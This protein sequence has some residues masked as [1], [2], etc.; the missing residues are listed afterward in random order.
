MTLFCS[1][2][3]AA[4]IILTVQDLFHTLFHPAATA[5]I[6]D[7]IALRIWRIFRRWLP[8]KL[9]FAGPIAFVAVVLFWILGI[10]V[11]FA[12]LYYPHLPQA[13]AFADGLDPKSYASFSGATVL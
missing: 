10:V 2:V 8:R 11:G 9:D 6:S 12:L 5:D 4:V 3:G 7:W 1:M 13:Y